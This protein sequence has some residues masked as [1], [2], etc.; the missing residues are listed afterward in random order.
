MPVTNRIKQPEQQDHSQ[1]G[2]KQSELNDFAATGVAL[3]VLQL[4][5]EKIL[6]NYETNKSL[7][8]N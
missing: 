2:K 5:V 6:S 7:L 4:H 3:H 1:E 8:L